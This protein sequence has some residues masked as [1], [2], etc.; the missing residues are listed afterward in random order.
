LLT[1]GS[2]VV[3]ALSVQLT[4]HESK[5]LKQVHT[6]NLEAYELFVRARSTPYPPIPERIKVASEMFEQVTQL[7]PEFAGGFA[8]LSL[9]LSLSAVFFHGDAPDRLN[10]AVELARKAISVDKTFGW[11]YTVLGMALLNQHQHSEAIGAIR[12]AIESQP[13]D[14]EAYAYIGFVQSLTGQ[15]DAAID[16]LER[17]IRLNPRFFFGPYLNLLGQTYLLAGDFE[18]AVKTFSKN[19]QQ[20]GPV[21]PPALAWYA[22]ALTRLDSHKEAQQVVTDLHEK[23]P[24]F[25][26][27]GWNYLS[28][29][30]SDKVR[31]RMVTDMLSAGVVG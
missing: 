7:D 21:G 31:D 6:T 30:T 4:Q 19:I 28:L 9:M 15:Y 10:C 17:A 5:N 8:G 16:S 13:N 27:N 11:S 3:G 22:A 2:K 12:M 18:L 26:L 24:G 23:F 29:I 20:L 14:A 25:T 1:V